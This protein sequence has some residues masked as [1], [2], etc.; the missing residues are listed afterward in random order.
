MIIDDYINYEI[1]YRNKYG[2][3]TIILI[4]FYYCFIIA[5]PIHY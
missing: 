5:T 1:E 4:Q 3:K 2:D